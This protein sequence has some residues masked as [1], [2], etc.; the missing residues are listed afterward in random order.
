MSVFATAP[1]P[2]F[3]ACAPLEVPIFTVR[4]PVPPEIVTAPVDVPVA[5]LTTPAPVG[6]SE[7]PPVPELIV[8]VDVVFVEPSVTVFAAPPVAICTVSA[9]ASVAIFTPPVVPESIV[10]V[11]AVPEPIV[12]APV[13]VYVVAPCPVNVAAPAATWKRD[14]LVVMSERMLAS[15]VPRLA[16]APKAL[17]FCWNDVP[18]SANVP[19]LSGSVHVRAAVRSAAVRVPVK[20][21]APP[22]VTEVTIL[23]SVAVAV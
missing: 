4:A 6:F 22:V 3:I 18:V 17:P 19:L 7:I 8:V 13:A 1:V 14:V 11:L 2:M 21:A 10:R 16:V 23:S 5:T 20:V 9:E 12:V 15:V